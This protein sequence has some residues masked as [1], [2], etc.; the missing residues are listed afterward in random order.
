MEIYLAQRA[1]SDFGTTPP[2]SSYSTLAL[3]NLVAPSHTR[4]FKFK[5]N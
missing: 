2:F 4:L 1:G 5:F 3:T